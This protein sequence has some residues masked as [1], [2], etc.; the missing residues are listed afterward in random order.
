MSC[1]ISYNVL[2]LILSDTASI[3]VSGKLNLFL[4]DWIKFCGSVDF[5]ST[6]FVIPNFNNGDP[7][8]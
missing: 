2:S 1:I 8:A 6:C 5:I 3:E 7:L 4:I